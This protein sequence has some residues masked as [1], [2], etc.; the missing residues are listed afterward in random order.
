MSIVLLSLSFNNKKL[1]KMKNEKDVLTQKWIDFGK[2][3]LPS[4]NKEKY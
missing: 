4:L 2:A 3:F 1:I